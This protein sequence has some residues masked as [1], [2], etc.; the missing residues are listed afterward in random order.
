M[1]YN[2]EKLAQLRTAVEAAR[3]ELVD[4]EAELADRRIDIEAFEFEYEAQV[5]VLLTQLTQIEAEG[6]AVSGP[7]PAAPQ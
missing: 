4:A 7:Y 6:E 3:Q 2:P 5:G 1:T